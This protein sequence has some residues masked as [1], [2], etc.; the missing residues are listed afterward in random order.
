MEEYLKDTL[1]KGR[2]ALAEADP[3]EL[4][5]DFLK[6]EEN[7]SGPTVNEMFAALNTPTKEILNVKP[8]HRR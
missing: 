7:A 5:E 6:F 2:Q 4:L 1:Q 8:L 3:D